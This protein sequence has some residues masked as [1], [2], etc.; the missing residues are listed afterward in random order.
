MG[1]GGG[2]GGEGVGF[3]YLIFINSYVM[4]NC[5]INKCRYI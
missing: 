3:G 4:W 2:G 1:G 5:L